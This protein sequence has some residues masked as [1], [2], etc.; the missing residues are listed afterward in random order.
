MDPPIAPTAPYTAPVSE[1]GIDDA[2]ARLVVDDLTTYV[3]GDAAAGERLLQHLYPELRAIAARCF[4]GQ[5][6]DHTLQPTALVHEAW[7]RIAAAADD[8]LAERDRSHF[9]ALAA[10][11]MRQILV[12]HA[13]RRRAV[14]RGGGE[15]P[16][17]LL[18]HEAITEVVRDDLPEIDV[19]LTRLAAHDARMARVVELRFFG[20]LTV[21]EVARLLDV[22]VTTVESDW[23]FAR[24]WL[25]REIGEMQSED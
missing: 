8:G 21:P 19:A 17:P 22:S 9:L 20:G 12:D 5:P 10:T 16:R 6:A 7:V 18:G 15:R 4:R 1:I 11:A 23:R 13:R 14:K 24:A 25:A 3:G 2:T